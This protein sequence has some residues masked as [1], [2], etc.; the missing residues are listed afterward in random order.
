MNKINF[1]QKFCLK[2]LIWNKTPKQYINHFKY[3][4]PKYA[5]STLSVYYYSNRNILR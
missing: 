5:L 4:I 3:Y 1:L 2:N